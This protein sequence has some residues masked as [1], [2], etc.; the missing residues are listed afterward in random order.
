MPLSSRSDQFGSA[1]IDFED[2]IIQ[3]NPGSTSS[4]L[5]KSIIVHKDIDDLGRGMYSDSIT[6]G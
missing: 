4:I 6:T 1:I 5:D 3:L 2:F